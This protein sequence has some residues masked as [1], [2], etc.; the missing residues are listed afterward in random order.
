MSVDFFLLR[1]VSGKNVIL[2]EYKNSFNY[3]HFRIDRQLSALDIIE[4]FKCK[5]KFIYDFLVASLRFL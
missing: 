3:R 5:N 2:T 4:I 1:N